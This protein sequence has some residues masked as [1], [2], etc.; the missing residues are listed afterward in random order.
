M[1][2]TRATSVPFGDVLSHNDIFFCIR[3]YKDVAIIIKKMNNAWYLKKKKRI[4]CDITTV[5]TSETIILS[6]RNK[7]EGYSLNNFIFLDMPDVL[8]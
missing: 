6:N 4:N 5:L 2:G 3:T 1:T 8:Y 7:T